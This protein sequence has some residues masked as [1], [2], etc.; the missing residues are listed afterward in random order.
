MV[1]D[2]ERSTAD[3][4]QI[5]ARVPPRLRP[6]AVWVMGSWLG[7]TLLRIAAR[8]V[9]LEMFDRSMTVAAQIFTSV[10]PV[11]IMAAVW[12]GRGYSDE[13]AEAVGMP[14]ETRNVLQD[15]LSTTGGSAFGI[16]GTLVVLISATSLSR[17]LT[18]AFAAIWE[19]PRPRAGLSQ[20][21]RWLG[22]VITLALSMVVI[23]WLLRLTEALPPEN[24]WRFVVPFGLDTALAV[25]VPWILLS[26]R[27]PVRRLLPGGVVF[28]LF[29]LAVRPA[30]Q[31]FLPHAL[32]GSADRYGTIGVAFTYIAWLYVLSFC[33]L[34]A[35]LIGQVIATDEGWLGRWIRGEQHQAPV[36]VSPSAAP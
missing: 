32:E 22:A 24:L 31:A 12:L 11:L 19:L 8:F 1:T 30:S 14:D 3:V 27:I 29:M 5:L 4:E 34:G 15:A 21:W 17:V 2:S 28:A 35:A 23:R 6:A 25:L 26:G 18:R 36:A 16:I 7:R 33:F 10:F 9:R 13:L 20:F